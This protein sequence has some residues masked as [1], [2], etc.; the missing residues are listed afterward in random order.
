MND[1][2]KKKMGKRKERNTVLEKRMNERKMLVLFKIILVLLVVGL[3]F[4]T[5][6]NYFS[7]DDYHINY[8]NPQITKG[9]AGIPEIFSTLYADESGMNF[10]YRPLVRTSFAIENQFT[11]NW[12]YNPNFSHVINILLYAIAVLLLYKVLRRFFRSYN[13]WFP[14][15]V[16]VLFL[17]HPTHTEVVASLK[18]RDILLNFIFSFWAIWQFIK[19]ADTSKTKYIIFGMLAYL[20]ALLSKETAIAQLAVFPLVLYF[21]TNISRKK[22]LTFSLIVTGLV[23]LVFVGRTLLLPEVVRGIRYMENPLVAEPNFI[24][25]L[26]TSFYILGW[27]LKM[28][29][30]PYPLSFY[31]GFN[32]IPIV[33]WTNIWVIL[34]FIAYM[35]MA[36]LAFMGI[37]KKKLL[38]FILLYFFINI[39]MYANIVRPVPG[40]V[41]DRFL[42]FP[43]LSFALLLVFLFFTISRA[44]ML[45]GKVHIVRMLAIVLLTVIVLVP[46]GRYTRARNF[47]WRTEYSLYHADR[48]HLFNS[49]KANDLYAY[50]L[51][52]KVNIE[53]AKPVNPYRFVKSMVD[54]AVMHY[55]QAVKLDSSHYSSWNNLGMVYSKIYGNQALLR[56]HSYQKQKKFDQAEAESKVAVIY[57]AKANSA[58]KQAVFFK[59]DYGVAYFNWGYAL[60][61]QDKFDSAIINYKQAI[62]IDGAYAK[63]L[64]RIANAYFKNGQFKTAIA[65]NNKIMQQFPK[66]DLP[67]VNMGNYHFMMDEKEVAVQYFEKAIEKGTNP[68]VGQLLSDYYNQ[69]GIPAKAA[70]FLEKSKQTTKKKED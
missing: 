17:S 57:F 7:L 1:F 34:S 26:S 4:N 8:R 53:F 11:R 59:P 23:V 69:Q 14:F 52:R 9:F 20:M 5:I 58:F 62:K 46:Y 18:N 61:L 63:T 15:L 31:Y 38:S 32:M 37:K 3:N 12:K 55:E 65:E 35:G 33:G 2:L 24:L 13:I 10:G 68:A 41:G 64:S 49:V 56:E 54:S 43:S 25:R 21:F 48:I 70:Y 47:N 39:S 16:V 66:S 19:W 50:E 67:Y 36:V 42:F 60:E 30:Y 40:I 22:L 27:Y 51:M 44:G 6:F 29:V 45:K 28:L